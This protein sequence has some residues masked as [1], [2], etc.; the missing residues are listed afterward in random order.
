MASAIFWPCETRTS[1]CRNFATISSAMYPFLGILVLLDAKRH[2][3]SRTTSKGV[4]HHNLK[5]YT[6]LLKGAHAA[7]RMT[8]YIACSG[9]HYDASRPEDQFQVMV[10]WFWWIMQ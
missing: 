10:R 5:R 6:A 2:S 3:S 8:R 7:A 4:D 1:T 9:F